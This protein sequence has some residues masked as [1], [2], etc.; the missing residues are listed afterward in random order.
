[1][2]VLDEIVDFMN[3]QM[4]NHTQ[5]HPSSNAPKTLLPAHII[6]QE[7][8]RIYQERRRQ[9]RWA[10]NLNVGL[11][12]VSG[13]VAIASLALLFSGRVPPAAYTAAGG[14]MYG[15][16]TVWCWKLSK[17]TND[18]LDEALRVLEEES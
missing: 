1:M 11:T 9:A 10:F 3:N 5:I 18:R 16:A 15:H 13:I 6:F 8:D 4:Q 12:G 2:R 7:R 14:A 17:D